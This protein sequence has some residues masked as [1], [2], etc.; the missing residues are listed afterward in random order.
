MPPGISDPSFP[1]GTRGFFMIHTQAGP[2]AT[3]RSKPAESG[4]HDAPPIERLFR[5]LEQ[6]STSAFFGKVSVSFQ[7]GKV[8]D[9]RTEQTKKIE[10]L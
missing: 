10:E 9:V 6:L 3:G 7:N 2:R 1:C 5:Y 4:D 8:C